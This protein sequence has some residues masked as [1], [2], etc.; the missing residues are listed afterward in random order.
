MPGGDERLY[1]ITDGSAKRDLSGFLEKI[2]AALAGGAR[3][4]QLREKGLSARDLLELARII[5]AKTETFGARL[6][7]NDRADI[8]L[9]AGADGVHITGNGYAP[10]EARKILGG[11]ALIGVSTHSVIDGRRAEEEG[12]DFVTFGPVYFT[13]S[14]AGYG[15]PLGIEKL[16]EATTAVKIPVFALGGITTERAAEAV[17]NGASGVAVISAVFGSGDIKKSVEGLLSALDH[18]TFRRGG[19]DD[20][21]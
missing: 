3:L 19:K 8:A 6:L 21:A 18:Q 10:F 5:K 11:K 13:R 2:D 4:I 15:E 17:S 20:P 12:A 9:V 7:I 1:L 14:K 16:R